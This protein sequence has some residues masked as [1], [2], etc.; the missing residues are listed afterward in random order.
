MMGWVMLL[1]ALELQDYTFGFSG[2]NVL[3]DELNGFPRGVTLLFG[4][5]VY[6]YLRSQINR[7]FK[8]QLAH[9]NH[10]VPWFFFMLPE[11][12]TFLQ[13]PDAVQSFQS[14]WV[15]RYGVHLQIASKLVSLTWYFSLSVQLYN[16]YRKWTVHEFSDT[17]K[18]SIR[19]YRG[20][21][22][23]MAVGMFAKESMLLLDSYYD[24][25]FQEDYYWN[26]FLLFNV[27][28]VSVNGYN[29]P[30]PKELRFD[31]PQSM[32][33]PE[34]EPEEPIQ[35]KKE[36]EATI[37]PMV[38]QK[39]ETVMLEDRAYLEPDITLTSLAK[40]L[41][42]NSSMLSKAINTS[43][44]LNF[45]DYI[46]SNRVEAFKAAAR[47]PQNQHMT[48]L[49][50]ALDCGFNSKATFNRAFK[51]ATGISPREFLGS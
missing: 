14:S 9:T 1:L 5:A 13:G 10:L 29:Q 20:F 11:L 8:L 7:D 30:Q 46:N 47:A 35:P 38:L 50:I 23:I 31:S 19:W 48:L 41:N 43:F 18:V 49:A 33:R 45:N 15:F 39:L 3:W 25:S 4:P 17:D 21:I 44:G 28:F 26:L 6:F 24:W 37:D 27:V 16:Q 2:I 40:R 34:T 32:T 36:S 42:T 12:V 22:Q 51:K